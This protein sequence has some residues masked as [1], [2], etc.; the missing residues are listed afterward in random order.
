[1]QSAASS[2]A[3]SGIHSV[4]LYAGEEAASSSDLNE[5]ELSFDGGHAKKNT[6]KSKRK[7][8]MGSRRQTS[9]IS[10]RHSRRQH[11]PSA[12]QQQSQPKQGLPQ[13]INPTGT[14][15]G[16][17]FASYGL[18]D[19]EEA[20]FESLHAQE[21]AHF[22]IDMEAPIGGGPDAA[23]QQQ[24]E[25][26][27]DDDDDDGAMSVASLVKTLKSSHFATMH[28][29]N[30]DADSTHGGDVDVEKGK[31]GASK[32]F[33]ATEEKYIKETVGEAKR[34]RARQ[35][36]LH[37]W[38]L[39]VLLAG[40]LC[41]VFAIISTEW[42]KQPEAR[43]PN[44]L[45]AMGTT[46]NIATIGVVK[47]CREIVVQPDP[48]K[49]AEFDLD[50]YTFGPTSPTA[51]SFFYKLSIVLLVVGVHC[52]CG[53]WIALLVT[54]K[55]GASVGQAWMR[56]LLVIGAAFWLAGVLLWAA[57]LEGLGQSPRA[58]SPVSNICFQSDVF[59]KGDCK[60]GI[61]FALGAAST[62]L[63]VAS[64]F[65]GFFVKST[66]SADRV[67]R[68]YQR[69]RKQQEQRDKLYDFEIYH[70]QAPE[71]FLYVKNPQTSQFVLTKDGQE[72]KLDQEIA[73][74]VAAS[75]ITHLT[76][77]DGLGKKVGEDYDDSAS[78]SDSESASS[79]TTDEEEEEEDEK[80][81]DDFVPVY[82]PR[83][84][85]T[86]LPEKPKFSFD[87]SQF[88]NSPFPVGFIIPPQMP[89]RAHSNYIRSYNALIEHEGEAD[90]NSSASF[91]RPQFEFPDIHMKGF[92]PMPQL[93]PSYSAGYPPFYGP[94]P[95]YPTTPFPP[96][97]GPHSYQYPAPPAPHGPPMMPQPY[98][99]GHPQQYTPQQPMHQQQYQQQPAPQQQQQEHNTRMPPTSSPPPPPMRAPSTHDS[100]S[101]R[102]PSECNYLDIGLITGE[103]KD[104]PPAVRHKLYRELQH[105]LGSASPSNTFK[106]NRTEDWT[107]EQLRNLL[108]SEAEL[109][110]DEGSSSVMSNVPPEVRASLE[111]ELQTRLEREISDLESEIRS[112]LGLPEGSPVTH[113][114][115]QSRYNTLGR[116]SL[117]NDFDKVAAQQRQRQAH[118][119][120][121]KAS[122][123]NSSALEGDDVLQLLVDGDD[124]LM[125][126]PHPLDTTDS[127]HRHRESVNSSPAGSDLT[128]DRADRPASPG[129][130]TAEVL[131]SKFQ[132]KLD[133]LA[134]LQA[135]LERLQ[136]HA[137]S[138]SK[139]KSRGQTLDSVAGT[140]KLRAMK[141]S[142]GAPAG[143]QPTF[144]QQAAPLA[145]AA[146]P[147]HRSHVSAP[148]H[149]I[150]SASP[151]AARKSGMASSKPKS[152]WIER[153]YQPTTSSKRTMP[154]AYPSEAFDTAPID[155]EVTQMLAQP[156][157]A[158]A[159]LSVDD[160]I[161]GLDE[162]QPVTA[163]NQPS[164]PPEEK[165]HKGKLRSLLRRKS[166]DT[167]A[168]IAAAAT[169][170]KKASTPPKD[171]S[172]RPG[173]IQT[174]KSDRM[175]TLFRKMFHKSESGSDGGHRDAEGLEF[176]ADIDSD[177]FDL[178][179]TGTPRNRGQIPA[180]V[181]NAHGSGA[182]VV[183]VEDES[184]SSSGDSFTQASPQVSR[185]PPQ[186]PIS[187][188]SDA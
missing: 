120:S 186:Y 180:T 86:K 99:S 94:P 5:S 43:E 157:H 138:H 78:E 37:R 55:K 158:P 17:Q 6:G 26:G 150:S 63:F 128:Y 41:A 29:R 64:A 18:L 137:H 11:T 79:K 73:L 34:M 119:G 22:D 169:T 70:K 117:A 93:P 142:M 125:T 80:K 111:H 30:G 122:S 134:N 57:S 95:S 152:P 32:D 31:H 124:E 183:A 139:S 171:A 107:T 91:S 121:G 45:A 184:T 162:S 141:R 164:T 40:C 77:Y 132:A 81:K 174:F 179:A 161:A 145:S 166:K 87:F 156:H 163:W 25:G 123:A 71:P 58:Q 28:T 88:G 49:P 2:D 68:S 173:H 155:D 67:I 108:G 20:M 118:S 75:E 109:S 177:A 46:P 14:G 52:A 136:P 62:I 42:V 176:D 83:Y 3:G 182:F 69:Y 12:G 4:T 112:N 39:L 13:S 147:A 76:K 154:Q 178:V 38:W 10:Q 24:G 153:K 129:T 16:A 27:S 114:A 170:D 98:F 144:A 51:Y 185:P 103:S 50:C 151:S 89:S 133:H 130:A 96:P 115:V 187:H 54:L 56:W 167:D 143:Y 181:G 148:S 36:Y 8:T 140:D 53:V 131:P 1:M 23:T 104:M 168:V 47:L 105:R 61:G 113:E 65:F 102:S 82:T 15:T 110:E 126:A 85:R 159:G 106:M 35:R 92:P 116:R 149:P 60:L 19:D 66:H 101:H 84:A 160:V 7:S 175:A 90:S 33:D 44:V 188:S 59:H 9:S 72:K 74:S 135:E 21:P 127:K 146:M 100:D 48:H 165:R 97:A 172:M